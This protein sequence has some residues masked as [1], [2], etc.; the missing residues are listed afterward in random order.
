MAKKQSLGR[1][2]DALIPK[3]LDASILEDDKHRVRKIM[4]SDIRPNPSQPRRELD[5]L[6]LAELSKS[7]ERH[8][9]VQPIVVITDKNGYRIVAGERRWRAAKAAGLKDIPAIVRSLQELEQL[10]LALIENI[11][12]VDLSPM[13]QAMAVYKLQQEFNLSL[14]EIG[15][16]LG[17]AASTISNLTRLLQLPE[18]AHQALRKGKISEGHARAIL[19]LRRWPDKQKE[20]LSSILNNGW[21]VRQAEQFAN[22]VKAG[23]GSL[24]ADLQFVNAEA[25][26]RDLGRNLNTKVTL[27]KLARGGQLII[28]F[29]NQQQLDQLAKK[30]TT[31]SE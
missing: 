8:G 3:N 27:K 7:I 10:E 25:L 9:V 18:P 29:E 2:F 22:G 23:T 24:K 17:K 15:Q 13:E 6:A 20:L 26:T 14:E 5:K 19:A 1:G 28:H 12:R 4:I 16:K 21:N 11:Q 30:L 31:S